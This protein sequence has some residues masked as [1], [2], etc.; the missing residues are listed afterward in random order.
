M[1]L[2]DGKGASN[3]LEFK[4]KRILQNHITENAVESLVIANL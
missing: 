2:L 3:Y 1:N 4:P